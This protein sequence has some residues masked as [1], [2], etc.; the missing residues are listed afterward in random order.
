MGQVHAV[1]SSAE[2]W[3][4]A[5]DTDIIVKSK[6]RAKAIF[7]RPVV[8]FRAVFVK[9]RED[10]DEPTRLANLFLTM[11]AGRITFIST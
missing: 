5:K 6:T 8:A 4:Y 7:F 10:A 9:T 3:K 2:L 1:S 11:R